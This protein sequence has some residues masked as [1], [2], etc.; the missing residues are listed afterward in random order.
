ML[1]KTFGSENH[2]RQ[3][4]DVVKLGI[5]LRDGSNMQMS[6]LSVPLICE[7]LSNQPIALA[8]S[9]WN[10]LAPL[11]L[12]DYSQGD[13]PLEIDILIGSDQY[14]KLV[15]GEMINQCNGPTAVRTRLGWVLSGPVEGL[16]QPESSVNLVS[17]HVLMVDDYQPP[18][19]EARTGSSV[20]EILGF[21]V[22]GN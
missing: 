13:V 5:N 15:T 16:S 7:P 17:T 22:Y 8:A 19:R 2:T 3:T 10:R 14:W 18:C 12:A 9:S 6:F 11:Q 21:G 20:K 1:I 4:C